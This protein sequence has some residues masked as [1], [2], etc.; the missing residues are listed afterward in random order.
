MQKSGGLTDKREYD[1]MNTKNYAIGQEKTMKS[2]P[3]GISVWWNSMTTLEKVFLILRSALSIAI[4]AAA[5]MGIL[6]SWGWGKPI[7]ALGIVVLYSISAYEEWFNEH[8]GSAVFHLCMAVAVPRGGRN[9]LK[10]R[11]F[12]PS[13]G[14]SPYFLG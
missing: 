8:R 3:I 10:R 5:W 2:I 7:V 9:H 13:L 4:I 1:R 12:L 14:L 11:S 6:A